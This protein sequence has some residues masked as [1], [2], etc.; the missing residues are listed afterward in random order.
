[1]PTLAAIAG[2][3][4]VTSDGVD[5]LPVM[6]GKPVKRGPLYWEHEGNRAIRDGRWKLVALGPAG[7]W[8]LYDIEKDR[9]EMHNLAARHP[10]IVARMAQQW[11]DWAR[12]AYV[13]PW[14]WA[15]QY[16]S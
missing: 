11:E 4:P 7:A 5:I 1:M 15:P 6:Q 2:A 16:K 12:K 14:I 13:L 3:Q 10:E 8:E 9:T